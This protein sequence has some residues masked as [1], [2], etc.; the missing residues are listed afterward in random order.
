MTEAVMEQE[1]EVRFSTEDRLKVDRLKGLLVQEK[2]TQW[3]IG[4]LV[5]AI[6]GPPGVPEGMGRLRALA[7][8]LNVSDQML[9]LYRVTSAQF[10]RHK[11]V[12]NLPHRAYQEVQAYPAIADKVLEHVAKQP[13]TYSHTFMRETKDRFLAEAGMLSRTPTR[14]TKAERFVNSMVT[15]R[16]RISTGTINL[17]RS[18]ALAIRDAWKD[19]EPYI[20]AAA[21]IKGE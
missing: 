8:E 15:A 7:A 5:L 21:R 16:E 13:R 2:Q 10:P 6:C 18:E 12:Y 1:A 20:L 19:L 14:L 17:S 3:E 4:D 11:R 9:A